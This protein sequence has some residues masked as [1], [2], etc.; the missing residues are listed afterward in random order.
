MAVEWGTPRARAVVAAATLGSGMTF[1]DGTVV[2]VALPSIGRDLDATF[3]ELQWIN[4]GYLLALSALILLGGALGD[5]LGRRRVFVLGTIAFAAAS[6]LCGLAPNAPSLIVARILQGVGAALLT[7]G[8]LAMIQ[9][10]FAPRDRAH[11]IGAWSGLGGIAAAL[12]PFLGGVLIDHASWRWIFLINLPVAVLTVVIARWVPE[13]SAPRGRTAFDWTGAAL[14]SLAL[15][16]VT[17]TLIEWG[18]PGVGWALASGLIAGAAFLM[19]ERRTHAPMVPLRLFRDRVFSAA[20]AMTL[21]VYA[22]LGAVLFF[23]VIQLQ[24]VGGYSALAAGVATLPITLCMLFLA[25]RAGALGQRIGP[26]IPM[27]VGP[28]VMAGG[29]LLLLRVDDS[30]SYVVDVLPGLTV[31]GLGLALMV[32]PLTA[33][34]LA[35]APDESAGIASGINNAVARAGSLLAIAALPVAV[36]LSGDDYADP[37]AFGAAYTSATVACAALLALGGLVS[38]VLVPRKI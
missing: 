10:A 15:G 30:V 7:P 9:G 34:V 13:S 3:A 28:I 22:A 27:T 33:T 19:V 32:A 6:L 16:G 2:N 8:S 21:L 37:G 18:R 12:G 35:A 11:A 24:T 20:N 26:R 38:W 23:L 29:T 5:R 36:G 25:A 1:L 14:A 31:F 4:N 17:F